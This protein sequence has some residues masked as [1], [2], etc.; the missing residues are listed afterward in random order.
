MR[1]KLLYIFSTLCLMSVFVSGYVI[2]SIDKA[3]GSLENLIEMHKVASMR[4]NM[5][6]QI[7]VVQDDLNL[8]ATRHARDFSQLVLHVS[9]MNRAIESCFNCHHSDDVVGRL[10]SLQG[11]AETYK[12]ALSRVYTMRANTQRLMREEDNA[13][14]VGQDLIQEVEEML[15]FTK[16]NLDIHTQGILKSVNRSKDFLLVFTVSAPILFFGMVFW[17]YFNFT[18]PIS[19]LIKA[20]VR[21]KGGDL[22]YRV[23][24]LNDEFGEVGQS[25]NEMS[26]SLKEVMQNMMRA[27]Q[28]VLMGEMT[29]RLAHEIKNPIT[30]IKLA[31]EIIRDE[32]EL[33]DE[34]KD[35][36]AKAVDQIKGMEKLMKGLLNFAKPL[37][38]EFEMENLN[39]IINTTCSTI[40]ILAE[41]RSRGGECEALH[42]IRELDEDLPPIMTDASQVR[43]I[44]LNLMLNAVDAMPEGGTLTVRSSRAPEDGFLRVDIVDTGHG[45]DPKIADKIFQPFYST[46]SKGTGLGLAIVTRLV[47]LLEGKLH[48]KS[49]ETLGTTFT[50]CLPV[51]HSESVDS[52]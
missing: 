41:E 19:S 30:G 8:K 9:S 24:K 52:K 42:L 50:I 33:S 21:L 25:F 17:F 14:M 11:G 43:Q 12:I 46:K 7:E 36:C 40:N 18:R 27:E 10:H 45:I 4:E 1:R 28:M 23:E 31:V 15:T 47:D 34:F 5:L 37:A 20:T 39:E 13:F 35:L 22:D 48:F 51:E 32:A 6:Q 49:E 29:S 44:L 3:T 2:Y 26:S 38:P 16:Q